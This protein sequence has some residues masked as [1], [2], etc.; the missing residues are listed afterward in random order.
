MDTFMKIWQK[1]V[2][3]C[4]ISLA[5]I[6]RHVVVVDVVDVDDVAN[7]VNGRKWNV[8]RNSIDTKIV[9]L[10]QKRRSSAF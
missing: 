9:L 6:C 8:V 3:G 7:V 4:K 1:F 5:G 10:P 2:A